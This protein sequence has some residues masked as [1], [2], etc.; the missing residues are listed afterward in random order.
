MKKL[1]VITKVI[2]IICALLMV[3]MVV[4]TFIQIVPQIRVWI[5]ISLG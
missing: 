4:T 3:I 1:D 5:S 2:E